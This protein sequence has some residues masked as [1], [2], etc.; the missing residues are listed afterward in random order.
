MDAGALQGKAC[1]SEGLL[2]GLLWL[3]HTGFKGRASVR[4][5]H[6]LPQLPQRNV[7]DPPLPARSADTGWAFG[8][9]GSTRNTLVPALALFVPV[10]DHSLSLVQHPISSPQ[11]R[12]SVNAI[13]PLQ[14]SSTSTGHL[15]WGLLRTPPW[16]PSSSACCPL[17][18]ASAAVP[19]FRPT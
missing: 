6:S 8:L 18:G 5:V 15:P 4:V 7:E 16:P 10:I 12:G 11:D 3:R 13:W 1:G 19:V 2:A 17:P 14:G 9:L